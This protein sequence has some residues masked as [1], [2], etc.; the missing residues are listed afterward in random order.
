MTTKLL[1]QSRLL[2]FT[3]GTIP[4][5][6]ASAGDLAELQARI[7]AGYAAGPV[8]GNWSAASGTFPSTR[9]DGAPIQRGDTFHVTTAGTVDGQ[10][11]AAGDYVQAL[12]D[13]PTPE[14]IGNWGV[15]ALGKIQADRLAAERAAAT[16]ADD[17]NAQIEPN[18]SA[19]VAAKNAAETAVA[20][21]EAAANAAINSNWTYIVADHAALLALTGMTAGQTALVRSPIPEHQWKYEGGAWVDKGESVIATKAPIATV[22]RI[23]VSGPSLEGGRWLEAQV[24]EEG[25]FVCGIDTDGREWVA[26]GGLKKLI[27]KVYEDP[28]TGL[29]VL[30]N[31]DA[32]GTLRH[33]PL[34]GI[35]ESIDYDQE[36]RF[37]SGVAFDGSEWRAEGGV[38]SQV[39]PPEPEP[40]P[41]PLPDWPRGVAYDRL[42]GMIAPLA[43]NKLDLMILVVGQSLAHGSTSIAADEPVTTVPEH[44]GFALMAGDRAYLNG[45]GSI[46]AYHDLREYRQSDEGSKETVNSGIA[47]RIMRGFQEKFGFKPRLIFKSVASGGQAYYGSQTNANGGLKRGSATYNHALRIVRECKAIS[48]AQGRRFAVAAVTFIHGEQDH[49]ESTSRENY[50]RALC[51]WL[52]DI[53]DDIRLITGQP[54]RVKGYCTQV[55]RADNAAASSGAVARIANAQLDAQKVHPNLRMVGP[56]YFGDQSGDNSHPAPR[57]YRRMGQMIGDALLAD[58]WGAYWTALYVVD[59]WWTS[60]TTFRLKF[61]R[62]VAI[63]MTDELVNVS[64]LGAGKGIDFHDGNGSVAP[65]SVT[66][67]SGSPDT[68]EVVLST[69]PTGKRARVQIASRGTGSGPGRLTGPRSGI[70]TATPFTTDPNDGAQLFHWACTQTVDI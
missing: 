46:T 43:A 61:S 20:L 24:D 57:A 65:S 15:G 56:I 60:S 33:V 17:A 29:I 48:E 26:D 5:A 18:V 36:G 42:S 9:P 2:L 40:E 49:N 27:A 54:D 22:E 63:E 30:N 62:P 4:G 8:V 28:E 59:A 13:A 6:G 11:F 67:V 21:S 12:V 23:M 14:F 44:P 69:A 53:S 52:D 58:L 35:F 70:R 38:I 25:R 66:L 39:L 34:I 1:D 45:S 47:D 64:A 19:A 55:N 68:V 3:G 50:T 51:N 7:D 37:V 16:A 32:P 10:S 31:L 41:E